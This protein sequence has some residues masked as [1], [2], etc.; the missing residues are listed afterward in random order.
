[1]KD[2]KMQ[3]LEELCKP[4]SEYLKKNWDPHC[5]VVITDSHIKLV[6]DDMGMPVLE[7]TAQEVSVQEQYKF[8]SEDSN[9]KYPN[10]E[11]SSN[12]LTCSD[13]QGHASL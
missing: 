6:R 3:E 7:E 13:N 11:K 2:K 1:M 12:Y 9:G 8:V 4:V 5:T 10:S